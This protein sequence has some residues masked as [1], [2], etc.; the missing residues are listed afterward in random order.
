MFTAQIRHKNPDTTNDLI[1]PM[2]VLCNTPDDV[3]IDN[4]TENTK[5]DIAWV[6]CE[7]EV[8]SCAIMVGGGPSL[9][10]HLH[11]LLSLVDKGGKI[12]A[13]NGAC[14]YL[15]ELGIT[16]EYQVI[17]DARQRTST[18]VGTAREHLIAS[19]CHPDTVDSASKHNNI[20]LW[21]LQIGD[22][23]QYFPE[24]KVNEGGYAIMQS[25]ISVG[26][27][28]LGLAYA[29]GFRDFHIFGYDSSYECGKSHAYKQDMNKSEPVCEYE[30]AGN[31]YLVSLAMKCQAEG[32]PRTA[33]LMTDSGCSVEVYGDGLLQAMYRGVGSL[34]EQDKY[35][36]MWGQKEYRGVAPGEICAQEFLNVVKPDDS[37]IDFGCGTG[38]GALAIHN[39]GHDVLCIDFASNCRD[40]EAEFLPFVEWDLTQ[41]IPLMAKYGYCTDVMEHIPTNDVDTVIRNIM[42]SV[43]NAF[44]QISLI[45]DVCGEMIGE[46]L[47]LTV[48]PY[49]WWIDKFESLGI[50]V[51]WSK[52]NE[53]S[54]M[55]YITRSDNESD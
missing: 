37:I 46:P 15:N 13:M 1:I 35:R 19:Q 20:R 42:A 47:H 2:K 26:N 21:H 27:S 54:A 10:N 38:R 55:F 5:K 39:A 7:D 23:E 53:D 4:I 40:E 6:E 34:S 25:A 16:P 3:L 49:S 41:P 22:I 48:K 29:L 50:E 28:S 43:P 18:L 30:F 12:F 9:K 11:E 33:K 51:K 24:S 32:F 36:L 52:D 17:V 44:F 45:D 8:S 14:G 31:K